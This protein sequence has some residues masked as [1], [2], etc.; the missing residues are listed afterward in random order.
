MSQHKTKPELWT[1]NIE[2]WEHRYS[3]ILIS[4]SIFVCLS[5]L[6]IYND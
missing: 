1:I 6:Y 3:A 4:V 5:V 2:P